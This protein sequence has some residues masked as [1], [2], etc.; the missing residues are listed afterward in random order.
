MIFIQNSNIYKNKAITHHTKQVYNI[1]YTNTN[2]NIN[3]NIIF[4]NINNIVQKNITTM[5]I[6]SPEM[7][8]FGSSD[9][10]ID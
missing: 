10:L 2:F 7:G 1:L 8:M 5:T 6:D 9:D 3:K 4:D